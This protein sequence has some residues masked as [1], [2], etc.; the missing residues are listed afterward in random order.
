[1]IRWPNIHT[2]NKKYCLPYLIHYESIFKNSCVPDDMKTAGS[3]LSKMSERAVHS[4]LEINLK[5]NE[6]INV[7]YFSGV[8]LCKFI[9]LR[10]SSTSVKRPEI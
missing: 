4:Q 9:V 1:M 8:E 2:T 5:E 3:T 6:I 7:W 10:N